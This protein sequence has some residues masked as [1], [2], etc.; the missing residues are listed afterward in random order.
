MELLHSEKTKVLRG[1]IYNVRN[2]LEAGWSEEVYHQAFLY[3]LRENSIPTV[4]KPR[5]S[6]VHRGAEIHRFE[7]DLIVWDTI[8]L[9]LKA[10]PYQNEFIGEQYAQLIHYLKFYG[11]DL[12]LLVNFG[13]SRV[14]IKRVI[15]HEPKLEIVEDYEKIKPDLSKKDRTCL[16]Q[17]RQHIL[18]IANQY[19]LGYPETTYR[20]LIAIELVHHDLPCV[21]DIGLTAVWHNQELPRHITSHLRVADNYL[22]HIRSL[23]EN[24]TVHDFAAIKTYLKN[25]GLKFGLIV[26][27]GRKQLQIF[28]LK[29]D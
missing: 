24:P 3:E 11:K 25:L 7:P 29:S 22:L 27:F 4:S 6:F 2:T 12:G 5:R 26:N 1:L 18:T 16:R 10:L 21:S 9:E 17:I 20:K 14:K 15:W 13:P 23:L 8:I 28:G 19:G